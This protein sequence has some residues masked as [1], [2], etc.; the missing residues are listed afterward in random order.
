MNGE[1]TIYSIFHLLKGK[2]SSQTIQDAHLYKI[3]RYFGVYQAVSRELLEKVVHQARTENWIHSCGEQRYQLTQAGENL[4]L[5]SKKNVSDLLY[6]NG[7]K[8]N[9]MDI[10][11]WERLSI[12]VQVVSNLVYSEPHYTPIQKNKQ[13]LL[14]LKFIFKKNSMPRDL[15]GRTLFLE[16]MDCLQKG[17]NINPSV[18]VFRL[19]G[20]NQIGLTA[21]QTAEKLG[22]EPFHYQLAFNNIL[23]YLISQINTNDSRYPLLSLL[24]SDHEQNEALTKSTQ[25]TNELLKKGYTI[26]EIA[27]FRN[28]KTSTIEDH[29]VE[30]A[31]NSDHFSIDDFVDKQNEQNILQ[32]AQQIKS[33]Q[34]KKIKIIVPAANYFEIR[35]VLAK[36]EGKQWN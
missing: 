29:I 32:A 13:T 15:L 20:Y 4:L 27:E 23:H 17:S 21:Q 7:W 34:L 24:L 19:T 28:L 31:L 9:Q 1:R 5:S 11:F 6:L 18:I 14:W 25:K 26:V 3:S 35:L 16:L 8:F 2:K 10:Q 22:M 30:I 33:K 12:F 36:H